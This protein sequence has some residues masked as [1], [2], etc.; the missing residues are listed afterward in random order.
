MIWCGL[1]SFRQ[2]C[3]SSISTSLAGGE[4]LK[5]PRKCLA[6]LFYI[7]T[8]CHASEG[9]TPRYILFASLR[10]A[11]LCSARLRSASTLLS[12]H[13]TARELQTSGS[14]CQYTSPP[15]CW[16]ASG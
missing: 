1:L 12:I 8:R 14:R 3:L 15:R 9:L 7:K 6:D 5:L 2:V 10:L 4:C 16:Q 11:R 13:L